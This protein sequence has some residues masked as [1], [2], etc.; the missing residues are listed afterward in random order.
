L[1]KCEKFI[2]ELAWRDFWQQIWVNKGDSI[3]SDLKRPQ[4]DVND[5][6]IAK[7]LLEKKTGINSIDEALNNLNKYG[8]MHNHMRMYVAS[9]A[10][11]IAKSHWKSPAKWMYYYLLDGDWASNALSWQWVAGSNSGKKYYANQENINKYFNDSQKNTF[12]DNSYEFISSMEI[13]DEVKVKDNFDMITRF[14]KSD[15]IKINGSLPTLIYNYYNIDPNW[16]KDEKANRI[17]IFEPK[18]F[19]K[20]PVSQKCIDFCINLSQNITN[21][22]IFFGSMDELRFNYK[23][24]NLIFKEHPLNTHYTGIEDQ[25]DW[26]FKIEGEYLSFFKYWNKIRKKLI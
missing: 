25:R 14:P 8:Y 22:Q 3:N 9:I 11:N 5:F 18:K 17:L 16:R 19:K 20:Y 21:I 1:K 13:P 12:L 23:I 15:E 7:S 26:L 24:S 2:Q 4:E 6:K 10:T